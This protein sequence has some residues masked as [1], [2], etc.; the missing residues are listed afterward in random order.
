FELGSA[1]TNTAEPPGNPAVSGQVAGIALTKIDP[2]PEGAATYWRPST[3]Y[4]IG[5]PRW[6]DP[7]L[8]DQS[9]FPVF[10]SKARNRPS[11]SPVNKT[12]PPVTSNEERIGY[13]KGTVHFFS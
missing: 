9:C 13:L 10:A 3:E 6:P 5:P 4:V 7:V 8:N 1:N 2:N 12:S 11:Q